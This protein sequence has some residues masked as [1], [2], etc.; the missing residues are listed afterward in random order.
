MI[1]VMP[2]RELGG[3]SRRTIAEIY[4]DAFRGDFAYFSKD[5]KVLA[6]GF[7]HMMVP[8]LFY[9]ALLDGVP[10][11][12]TACT[13]G[14]QSCVR[15]DARQLRRHFGLIKGS[16]SSAVFAREFTGS[17]PN[18]TPTSA[19]LEFVGTAQAYQGRGVA[20]AMLRH[21]LA[22]PQY[23]DYRLEAISD[24]NAPALGL[25]AGLGFVEYRR[26]KVRHT[27]MTGINHYISMQLVQR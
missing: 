16:I 23:D 14:T 13:D 12:I 17:V 8:E 5:P 26:E 7:E 11:G 27:W 15:P 10:A 20:K 1:E 19:S 4:A 21:L 25:Y 9:V 24:V 18:M 6:D 3:D 22:L 2:A